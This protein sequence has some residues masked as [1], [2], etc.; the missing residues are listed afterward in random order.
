MLKQRT[1]PVPVESAGA[2]LHAVQ[3]MASTCSKTAA[4]D[5]TRPLP[6][7]QR[8]RRKHAH[9]APQINAPLTQS[10]PIIRPKQARGFSVG[11]QKGAQ[12]KLSQLQQQ[13]WST[14]K[15]SFD[16]SLLEGG[17]QVLRLCFS[18]AAIMKRELRIHSIR[19]KRSKPGLAAQHLAGIKLASDISKGALTGDVLGS[20]E[21]GF[22]PGST[23]QGGN[24]RA[25]IQT[26]GSIA[27]LSQI[28]LPILCF[29]PGA[30]SVSMSGGT[31]VVSAPPRNNITQ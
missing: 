29:C 7:R 18:I 14:E 27:L 31:R 26:A 19:G 21:V 20:T 12:P 9:N 4:T 2:W 17:G 25:D 16:G 13:V 28:A 3:Q 23:A 1:A 24:F 15:F 10:K 22:C 11:Q 5:D 8:K 6:Q 30:S